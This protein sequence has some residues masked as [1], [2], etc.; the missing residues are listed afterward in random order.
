MNDWILSLWIRRGWQKY[1][2]TGETST[3]QTH[4][5]EPFWSNNGRGDENPAKVRNPANRE[6]GLTLPG[7]VGRGL[8]AAEELQWD[9]WGPWSPG[10]LGL[11]FINTDVLFHLLLTAVSCDRQS[12]HYHS[13]FLG[14][15]L[16][17]F[18]LYKTLAN[19]PESPSCDHQLYLF[20]ARG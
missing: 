13:H 5:W 9:D 7:E 4:I 10:A 8:G 1:Q 11:W 3:G 17:V 14:D 20:C 19:K 18:R 6:I 2:R 12:R 15:K 16:R